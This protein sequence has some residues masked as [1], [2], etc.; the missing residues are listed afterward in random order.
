MGVVLRALDT[1]L[2]RPVALKLLPPEVTQDERAKEAFLVESRVAASLD[3]PG[4]L[5]IHEAGVEDGVPFLAMRYVPGRDL[6]RMLRDEAPLPPVTAL[7]IVR[8]V[9]AALDFAHRRGVLHGDV[10]PANILVEDG[11][12]LV[13]YLA[14]FGLAHARLFEA[15]PPATVGSP[16][17][18]APEVGSGGVVDGRADQYAVA[19]VL[20]RSLGLDDRRTTEGRVDPIEAP[21]DAVL[22]RGTAADPRDRFPDCT[23][24][25]DAAA[26]ALRAPT[27]DPAPATNGQSE[28]RADF[29]RPIGPSG[30][31]RR[32][33]PSRV[34]GLPAL[35]AG[36]MGLLLLIG[37]AVLSPSLLPPEAPGRS[38]DPQRRWERAAIAWAEQA[39]AAAGYQPC[40]P[41]LIKGA[42]R[43]CPE[44]SIHCQPQRVG[45]QFQV[46]DALAGIKCLFSLDQPVLNLFL[47]AFADAARARLWWSYEVADFGQTAPDPRACTDGGTGRGTFVIGTH[48]G[49]LGCWFG[50]EPSGVARHWWLAWHEDDTARVG[51]LSSRSVVDGGADDHAD[52]LAELEARW[53]S[54][55][56]PL[57]PAGSGPMPSPG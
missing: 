8:Q 43:R 4:I 41:A 57:G 24:L 47:F 42:D 35:A 40:D 6:E 53:R 34:L 52:L 13:A 32:W 27:T 26:A 10:K 25:V 22:R 45:V 56:A 17:Y 48:S 50:P 15:R 39:A 5:P 14:D 44:R 51:L 30:V 46:G 19:R 23:A 54:L 31:S 18:I 11:P 21:V 1:A 9:A 16:G 38:Q 28:Q 3:H 2:G 20:I 55:P 12:Q 29:D 37:L 36:T 33:A 49:V 7:S